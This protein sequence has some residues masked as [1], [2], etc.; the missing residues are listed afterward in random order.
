[1]FSI[2]RRNKNRDDLISEL[3]GNQDKFV[4]LF[5]DLYHKV[6]MLEGCMKVLVPLV[7]AELSLII[8]LVW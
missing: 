1:M 8:Y 5:V 3:K 7:V 4:E 2:G 6:G